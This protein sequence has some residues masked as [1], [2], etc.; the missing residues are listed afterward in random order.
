[1]LVIHAGRILKRELA[2]RKLPANHQQLQPLA[3]RIEVDGLS[4][5]TFCS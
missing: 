4:P 1:M 3:I 5:H 2:T